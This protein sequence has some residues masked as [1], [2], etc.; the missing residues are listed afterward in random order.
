M[1]SSTEL[2]KFSCLLSKNKEEFELSLKILENFFR[3]LLLIRLNKKDLVL[4]SFI[5]KNL[6][7]ISIDYNCDGIDKII[8]KIYYIK[9][10]LE[11]NCNYVLL[12][13]NL[14]LY[15]LEVKFLCKK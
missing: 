2:L 12:C 10:Q 11:F 8:K 15:I 6:D 4:N 7:N 14:L 5:I 9:K 13:D 3:D 1:K